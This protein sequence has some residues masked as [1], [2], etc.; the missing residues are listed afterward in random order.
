MSKNNR[1]V[2][3]GGGFYGL[4][5]ALYLYEEL[6]QRD[7]YILEKETQPMNRAA[8]IN[9]ALVHNGY[10][11]PRSILTGYRSKVNFPRFTAEYPDAIVSS[12]DKYYGIAKHLSKVSAYQF[13]RFSEKIGAEIEPAPTHIQSMFDPNLTE[14][15]Y[16]VKEYAFN[17]RNLRDDL[18]KK[19][20][21]YPSIKL[22]TGEMVEKIIDDAGVT[23]L[24]NIRKIDAKFVLNCTYASINTIHRAS[25]L[26]LVKLKHEITE[27]CLVKMPKDLENFSITMMDG[28][29]FSIM[30]FPS[31]NLFTLSHVRYTPHESWEDNE[32]TEDSRK[33]AHDYLEKLDFQSNYKQMYNDVVR[34]IPALEQMQFVESLVEVKTVLMKSEEDD[35]RPILYRNDFGIQN[36]VCIMGGKL[37][38]IYDVFDELKGTYAKAV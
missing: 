9:Q 23:V 18:L 26:A 2:I 36:Y 28:P 6:G 38:N 25:Q 31:K 21:K 3:I 33:N 7:I 10:H 27:M 30:P 14:A 22:C 11:Y 34:F 32:N 15:V 12:F 4:R 37:D 13:R 24:T 20:E 29:F 8:Y 16:K 17:S 5:I 1:T 19:I 35:S